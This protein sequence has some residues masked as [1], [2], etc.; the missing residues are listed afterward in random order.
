MN[1][2]NTDLTILNREMKKYRKVLIIAGSDSGGGAGIQADLK[3]VSALGCYGTT[4][5]TAIT[6]QNTLGVNAI[7]PIPVDIIEKQIS[8]VLEDIGADAVKIG[9]LHSVEIIMTVYKALEERKV[10]NI[11]LDPVM[12][13]ASGDKL[14]K[15]NTLDTLTGFLFPIADI[16]T[17]NIPETNILLN[18]DIAIKDDMIESAKSLLKF[19]SKSVLLKGGHMK[20]NI[21]FDVYS[22]INGDGDVKI[23]ENMKVNT[24]NVHGTGCTLSSAIASFL[25]QGDKLEV[26]VQ[27]AIDYLHNAIE[28]GKD[29]ITGLGNGPVNHFFNPKKLK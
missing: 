20:G 28:H 3:T 8:A 10:K 5:I 14:I 9:M 24:K 12:V 16:I 27:N 26:A 17:P 13:S 19:G 4:A 29:Y 23:F 21:L 18:C 15:D 1:L 6:A 22:G 25:A 2:I 11:V 7:H